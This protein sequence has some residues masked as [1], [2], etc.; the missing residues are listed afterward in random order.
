MEYDLKKSQI[1]KAVSFSKF[2]IL[3]PM[4]F[5]RILFLLTSIGSL[6]IY[7]TDYALAK[8]AIQSPFAQSRQFLGLFH[9]FL[10]FCVSV[11]FIE[12]FFN[13]YL[14]YP[15]IGDKNNLAEFFDFDA[16]KV[17][18]GISSTN[19]LLYAISNYSPAQNILTRI[20]INPDQL[21]NQIKKS[22]VDS[23]ENLAALLND[24]YNTNIKEGHGK[25]TLMDLV[26][27]LFDYNQ[28][29]KQL[30]IDNGLDKEDLNS[31]ATWYESYAK[32]HRE[33]KMFWRLDNL[34]RKP[35][36]GIGW[37][38]GYPWYLNRY[39][40]DLTQQFQTGQQEIKL[41]GRQKTIDQLEQILSRSGQNNVLLVG[42]AGVGKRTVVL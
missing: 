26:A 22:P 38:Y 33:L 15:K 29:F 13:Y 17:L 7:G 12:I 5:W 34:L 37:I 14:K 24:A 9:I 32:F 25:I 11:V 40:T 31:L 23:P 3:G 35:P 8:L 28:T 20:G 18:D 39:A 10:P 19:D 42:E 2:L 41:I 30:A 21:K 27:S 1:Y 6:A 4:K 36:I 16:A